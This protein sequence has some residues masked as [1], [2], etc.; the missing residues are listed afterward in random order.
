MHRLH[1]VGHLCN[2]QSIQ[3]SSSSSELSR[4]S[5]V[6]TGT[7]PGVGTDIKK[8]WLEVNLPPGLVILLFCFGIFWLLFS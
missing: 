6:G 8:I 5:G 7:G 3:N 1:R 2:H 4:Q